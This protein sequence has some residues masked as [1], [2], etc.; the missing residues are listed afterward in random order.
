MLPQGEIVADKMDL[1]LPPG[2]REVS[3]KLQGMLA[4]RQGWWRRF[5]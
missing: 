3:L 4:K 5:W 1:V 2:F